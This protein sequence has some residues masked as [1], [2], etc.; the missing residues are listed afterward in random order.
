MKSSFIL[1]SLIKIIFCLWLC[2][3]KFI[4]PV[5]CVYA[6]SVTPETAKLDNF[7]TDT[8]FP[9]DISHLTINFKDLDFKLTIT[10]WS[11]HIDVVCGNSTVC[12][13]VLFSICVKLLTD[14]PWSVYG[15]P[16]TGHV[17]LEYKRAEIPCS[18]YHLQSPF[19]FAVNFLSSC[20]ITFPSQRYPYLLPFVYICMCLTKKNVSFW[21]VF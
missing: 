11:L 6:V 7:P 19:N 12:C 15:T 8:I 2:V 18:F 20:F 5:S 3:C 4:S 16:P 10:F 9:L 14:Q 1:C 17:V 13:T 21:F